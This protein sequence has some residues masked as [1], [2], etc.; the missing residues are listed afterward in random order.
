MP[1][2]SLMIKPVSGLCNMQ[3]AYCFYQDVSKHRAHPSYGMMS[4]ETLENLMRRAFAYADDEVSIVFQGGEPTLAG[5]NFYREV[6]SFEAKYNARRLT[7]HHAIQTNGYSLDEEWADIFLVGNFLVGISLDGTQSLHDAARLD[8]SGHPTY[9]RVTHNMS[10]LKSKGV[11]YNVLCVITESIGQDPANVFNAL[12][13]Y[14][15][16]QFIPY[17]DP[18]EDG[19]TP[20]SFNQTPMENFSY[21]PLICMRPHGKRDTRLVCEPLTTG[22]GY[23]WGSA[24]NAVRCSEDVAYIT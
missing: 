1:P 13:R 6:L 11:P 18:L 24:L 17:I 20:W 9:E 2:L 4:M 23:F 8:A 22:S 14:Q 16:M 5:K 3:C 19:Q 7:I 10:L 21:K 12:Q 15:Y